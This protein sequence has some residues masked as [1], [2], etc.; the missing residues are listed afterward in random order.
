MKC[1][2]LFWPLLEKKR[3]YPLLVLCMKCLTDPF[4]VLYKTFLL[5]PP[6]WILATFVGHIYPHCVSRLTLVLRFQQKE[7]WNVNKEERS[8][9]ATDLHPLV[10]DLDTKLLACYYSSVVSTLTR[11]FSVWYAGSTAEDRKAVQMVINTA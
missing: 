3:F 10:L 2:P 5:R 1:V 7:A 4:N 11:C 8:T 6:K 9:G